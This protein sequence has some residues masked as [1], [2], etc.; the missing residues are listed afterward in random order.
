[1][2]INLPDEARTD[3]HTRVCCDADIAFTALDI[4]AIM[5]ST[6]DSRCV[7]REICRKE[8]SVSQPSKY[9]QNKLRLSNMLREGS[10]TRVKVYMCTRALPWRNECTK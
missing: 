4:I 2:R 9:V 6:L 5:G 3:S 7:G 8:M 1:M 10:V